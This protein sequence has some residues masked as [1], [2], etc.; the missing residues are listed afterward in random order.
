VAGE[1]TTLTTPPAIANAMFHATGQRVR[2]VPL[3][4]ARAARGGGDEDRGGDG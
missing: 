3:N 4:P 2:S 1:I